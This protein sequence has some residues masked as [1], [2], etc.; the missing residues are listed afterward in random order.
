MTLV[1]LLVVDTNFFDIKALNTIISFYFGPGFWWAGSITPASDLNLLGSKINFSYPQ[2]I[3]I[4]TGI[5]WNIVKS[6]VNIGPLNLEAGVNYELY[7]R[8]EGY[9]YFSGIGAKF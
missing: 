5:V 4:D 1:P 7:N 9:V 8:G 3:W 6:E 2:N